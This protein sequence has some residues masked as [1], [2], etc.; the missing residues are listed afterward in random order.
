[1]HRP[2]L[3]VGAAVGCAWLL[4][5]ACATP[6]EPPDDDGPSAGGA[7]TS[8]LASTTTG[9]ES[10]STG[11]SG[12]SS[13][14]GGGCASS[15][16]KAEPIPLDIFIML[17]QSGSMLQ[18]AGNGMNKWQ[19]VK[20]AITAFTQD[21]ASEGI[22]LGLQYFGLPTP[23]IP[24]CSAQACT[25]DTD[26]TG[27]CGPCG[28]SGVCQA[29]FNPDED[30]CNAIDYA[31]AEV[32]IQ[33]LPDVQPAILSSLQMHA[34][35]TNTPTQPALDGAIQYAKAWQIAH[36]DH[37]TVVA[38]ATDGDPAICGTDLEVINGIAEAGFTGTPSIKTFV[39][40]VGGSLIALDGIA[41]AGGTT[42][43][44]NVDFDP[45]A[46]ELFLDALNTIRGA[47]LPCTYQIPP[48]PEGMVEDFG[49]VNVEYTPGDGGPT[50]VI[51]KVEDEA[52]CPTD[53]A[54]WYYDD[55]ATPTQIILC[56]VTCDLISQD[57]TAQVDIAIGCQTVVP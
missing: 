9:F 48:P 11:G 25:V 19:T 46:T 5:G 55:N 49:L 33:T 31:W 1:M 36:P 37:I 20:A 43:A 4:V 47:A 56:D 45:D 30:S 32:P 18:D 44:F 2:L 26:C 52:D 16:S 28:P 41:A 42:E 7:G 53:G 34:P 14:I 8:T 17:D 38:F 12:G 3:L 35:G 15:S 10:T 40:G 21:D 27:G 51:P 22:G 50:Q 24:G 54:G 23:L 13:G 57:I 39:V 29:P 6:I